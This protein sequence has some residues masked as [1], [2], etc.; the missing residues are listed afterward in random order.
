MRTRQLCHAAP[1]P[2][3]HLSALL[4]HLAPSQSLRDR[5]NPCSQVPCPSIYGEASKQLSIII[6]AYNEEDRL[7]ATLQETL[8]C[9]G[10][11]EVGRGAGPSA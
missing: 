5:P 1:L 4:P 10:L 6:P 2:E 9:G 11:A 8:R 7:P 3:A